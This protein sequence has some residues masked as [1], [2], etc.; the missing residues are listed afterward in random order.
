MVQRLLHQGKA[1]SLPCLP[2]RHFQSLPG[3]P[4]EPAG[5]WDHSPG[6]ALGRGF[7]ASAGEDGIGAETWACSGQ[8]AQGERRMDLQLGWEEEWHTVEL[9]DGS[10]CLGAACPGA[11]GHSR[12]GLSQLLRRVPRDGI[13]RRV[14]VQD[15]PFSTRSTKASSISWRKVAFLP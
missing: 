6:E 5:R 14:K 7:M 13:S 10:P 12:S 3:R 15:W 4:M 2:A 11:D 8:R 9:W 1:V